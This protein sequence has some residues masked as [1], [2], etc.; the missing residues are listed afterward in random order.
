MHIKQSLS[1]SLH[2]FEDIGGGCGPDE[3][4]GA[5]VVMIE[6]VLNRGDQFDHIAKD[7]TPETVRGKVAKE[8][9]DH[10]QPRSAGRREVDMKPSMAL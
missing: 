3:W 4:F 6:V 2:F 7:S 9:F 8:A 5:F 1:G 10:V